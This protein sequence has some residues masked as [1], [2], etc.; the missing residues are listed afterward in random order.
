MDAS[1]SDVSSGF[2]Q[3]QKAVVVIG[4]GSSVFAFRHGTKQRQMLDQCSVM[5]SSALG[6]KAHRFYGEQAKHIQKYL[7]P[8]PIRLRY[9]VFLQ[10]Q[11]AS[12]ELSQLSLIGYRIARAFSPF[13]LHTSTETGYILCPM[14]P[15]SY[16]CIYCRS[17]P[18]FKTCSVK[19][20]VFG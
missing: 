13:L 19:T 11:S 18:A 4:S 20:F 5:L 8:L 2:K 7:R 14:S 3:L 6:P 16:D 10:D 1:Y 12:S 9:H 17:I 15:L